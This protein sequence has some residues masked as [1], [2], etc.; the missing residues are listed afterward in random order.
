MTDWTNCDWTECDLSPISEASFP[1]HCDQCAHHLTGLGD[2]G[3]CPKCG[4]PFSRR[5]RLW[6]TYGPEAFALPDTD[7]SDPASDRFIRVLLTVLIAVLLMPIVVSIYKSLFG[8][9]DVL[10]T[11]IAWA[12]VAIAAGWIVLTRYDATIH[13]AT[14]ADP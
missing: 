4:E 12:V 3:S 5:R 13:S 1:V 8:T 10:Y 7:A 2:T 14:D 9:V 11:L 6:E